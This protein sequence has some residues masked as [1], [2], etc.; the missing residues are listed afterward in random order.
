MKVTEETVDSLFGKKAQYKIPLFQRHYVW[1]KEDQWQPLWNDIKD[2]YSQQGSHFT[3]T[4]VIQKETQS[5]DNGGIKNEIYEIIDGQQ[6]LTTFQIILC[7]L[8]D[9]AK[10]AVK[11]EGIEED[12]NRLILNR[13]RSQGGELRYKLIPK[14][15]D[16][17]QFLEL[18][19]NDEDESSGR[20][21]EAYNFFK[22]EIVGYVQDTYDKMDMLFDSIVNNFGFVQILL[23]SEDEPEKIF[24]SINVRGKKPSEFDLLRN[25]LFLRAHQDRDRLYRQ[26]WDHF[27]TPYWNREEK[28]RTLSELFLHHFLMAKL[29]TEKVKV[30]EEFNI[31]QKQYHK[32]LQNANKGVE[33]EFSELKRYSQVYQKMTDCKGDSTI[34]KRMKFYDT[35]EITTLHPFILF[36]KCEV[37]LSGDELNY[38]FDIL[39]SYTVRRMLCCRGKNGLKNYNIFFSELIRKFSDDF[40]IEDLVKQLSNQTSGTRKY[41]KDKEM[42]P[43]LHIHYDEDLQLFPEDSTI[44]FP[45]NRAVRAALERRWF[46][47]A[48]QIKERLIRYILYQIEIM[49]RNENRFTE[50]NELPFNNRLTLEHIIPIKWK[51]TWTLPIGE[52]SVI[53][54]NDSARN[55]TVSVDRDV[56]SNELF[57]R[58]LFSEID[59][60]NPSR[61]NLAEASY[62]DAFNLAL[63]RDHLLQSIGN[64]TLV[65][66]KLN[67]SMSNAPFSDK[68]GA[69]NE[70]S[71]LQLNNEICEHDTWDINEIQER[72]AKLITDVCK[73]WPSLDWFAENLP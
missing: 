73:I 24:E 18:V 66:R 45:D 34:E 54:E 67:A 68:K 22:T 41:P 2:R 25:N 43:A 57:Y 47:T 31:Y 11:Y 51:G 16:K 32:K 6:R 13:T 23:D 48:G 3:G 14:D 35:F 33:H 40:S 62:L 46:E 21:R 36:V 72:A 8:R 39:E 20:I 29:G 64:L 50:T 59:L 26:Y 9:I 58:D 63:A 27:E 28:D 17:E 49:K 7:A 30:K 37:G 1:D 5:N 12:A 19:D 38:V 60:D 42:Q 44:V 71:I 55:Y 61:D 70:H 65:T 15:F 52:G 69:L 10:E 53:Y 4:L 56:A